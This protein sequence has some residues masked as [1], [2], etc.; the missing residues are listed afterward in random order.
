MKDLLNGLPE[1][2]SLA[3]DQ[4]LT[5]EP[6]TLALHNMR[7]GFFYAKKCCRAM[8][9]DDDIYSAVYEALCKAANNF[10]P[11]KIRFFAYS[12]PYVRGA[13]STVWREKNVVKRANNAVEIPM[14]EP[15][16][17]A[18]ETQGLELP[19]SEGGI[20]E[21]IA[22]QKGKT[23]RPIPANE[24]EFE[25]LQIREEYKL[26]KPLLRSVL[27]DKEQTVIALKYKS[28]L[29]FQKIGELLDTSR[30]DIQVTHARA[31]KKLR[32]AAKR[33]IRLL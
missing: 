27:T 14:D 31:L 33:K 18:E 13:L 11:G 10:K 22:V 20:T 7:E 12:K 29:T 24:F 1:I 16:V 2:D 8:L 26:L 17:W 19:E 15:A 30:P 6:E 28:G 9:S 21:I 25:A 23:K 3:R 32:S 4:E 5:V